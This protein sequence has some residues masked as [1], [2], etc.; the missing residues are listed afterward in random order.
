MHRVL[1]ETASALVVMQALG[2]FES[3]WDAYRRGIGRSTYVL[4]V[5]AFEPEDA[6]F[7]CATAADLSAGV[8]VDWGCPQAMATSRLDAISSGLRIFKIPAEHIEFPRF[9]LL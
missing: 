7:S 2:V 3:A 5:N 6:L 4:H 1:L 9:E 8:A